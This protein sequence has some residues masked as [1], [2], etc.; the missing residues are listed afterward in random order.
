MVMGGY[1]LGMQKG[2][3]GGD[4]LLLFL[5]WV[6]VIIFIIFLFLEY[7]VILDQ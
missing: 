6:T 5:I 1:H 4:G 7:M 3:S 2:D